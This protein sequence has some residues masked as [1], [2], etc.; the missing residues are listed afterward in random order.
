MGVCGSSI[1]L[2][3]TAV[4]VSVRSKHISMHAN[5]N[6]LI[7]HVLEVDTKELTQMLLIFDKDPGHCRFKPNSILH[8]QFTRNRY[9]SEAY[10]VGF[11]N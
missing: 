1:T 5:V 3:P 11:I 7:K 2:L 10:C 4:K 6:M 9:I 8:K